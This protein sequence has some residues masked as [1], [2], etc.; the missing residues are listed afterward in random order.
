MT[1]IYTF[2]GIINPSKTHIAR[3]GSGVNESTNPNYNNNLVEL[4]TEEYSVISTTNGKVGVSCSFLKSTSALFCKFKLDIYSIN[5]IKLQF[6]AEA[7]PGSVWNVLEWNGEK[8]NQR[9]STNQLVS[10]GVMQEVELINNVQEDKY[11]TFAIPIRNI[12][13]STNDP[14]N[15]YSGVKLLVDTPIQYGEDKLSIYW[16]L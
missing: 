12:L 11:L 3:K 6:I 9:F 13:I 10:S 14:F 7:A 5:N 15:Y 1:K 8:W 2:D 4:T 16:E